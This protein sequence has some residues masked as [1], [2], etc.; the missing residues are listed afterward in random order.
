MSSI[1]G[2]NAYSNVM[3]QWQIQVAQS[4]LN[5]PGQAPISS[6]LTN[7]FGSSTSLNSQLASLIELTQYAMNAMGLS[8]DSRVT[9]SQISKYRLQLEEDFDNK[10]AEGLEKLGLSPDIEFAIQVNN[11]GSGVTIQSDHADRAKIQ[12]FFDDN[13]ELV[14]TYRQ[15]EALA[16]IDDAREAMQISPSAIRKRLQIESMVAWWANS[17]NTNSYFGNYAN[18]SFSLLSGLNLN[19]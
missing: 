16:G 5:S 6:S 2:I 7:T 11:D 1:S 13:P 8:E 10:V 19:V 17:G 14:K 12:S 9:F 3:N 15:I 18:N 4:S